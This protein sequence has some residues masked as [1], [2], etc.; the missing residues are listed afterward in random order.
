[1]VTLG[2]FIAISCRICAAQQNIAMQW[3]IADPYWMRVPFRATLW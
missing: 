1:L 3:S 2:R